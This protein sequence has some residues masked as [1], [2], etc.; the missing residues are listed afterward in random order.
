ML[1]QHALAL[2]VQW[3]SWMSYQRPADGWLRVGII[4]I[5]FQH[6]ATMPPSELESFCSRGRLLQGYYLWPAVAAAA[7][8]PSVQWLEQALGQ[9]GPPPLNAA[10]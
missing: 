3:W 2:L 1:L 4:L 5:K 9:R 6:I 7:N 10:Q 8:I